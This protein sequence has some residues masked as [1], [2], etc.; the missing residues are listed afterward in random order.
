MKKLLILTLILMLPD[1]VYAGTEPT[2]SPFPGAK[3]GINIWPME[4]IKMPGMK[5]TNKA[6]K[7]SAI[8]GFHETQETDQTVTFLLNI[9]KIAAQ[10]TRQY[11]KMNNELDTHLRSSFS[12]FRLSFKFSGIPRV[13]KENVLGF[14][15]AGGYTHEK[16]WD[17]IGEIVQLPAIGVCSFSTFAIQSVIAS[18]E[19]ID[20][21][22]N[23]KLSEKSIA[24]NWNT[25]FL[26][27]VSW[28][29]DTRRNSLECANKNLKLENMKEIIGIAKEI[30]KSMS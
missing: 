12:K 23:G 16:G 28:Y 2:A 17:G 3:K 4:K 25:G 6:L 8:N 24:G 29:T 27:T 11:D 7:A 21:S 30:D 13:S 22:V 1:L 9:P 18:K 14:S 19:N 5:E 15:P 26:Y 10:E 20:Y